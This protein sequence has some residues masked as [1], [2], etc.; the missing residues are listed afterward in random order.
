MVCAPRAATELKAQVTHTFIREG[1]RFSITI[2]HW[3]D[4]YLV[5]SLD[6]LGELARVLLMEHT[7]RRHVRAT[8]R[9]WRAVQWR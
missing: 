9:G 8:A 3:S 6:L 4:N 7:A 1:D 2:P 5:L